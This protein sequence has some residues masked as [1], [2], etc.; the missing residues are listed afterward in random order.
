MDP[1][2][3]C[4]GLDLY[5]TRPSNACKPCRSECGLGGYISN[6]CMRNSTPSWDAS[7][8]VSCPACMK[9]EYMPTPCSGASYKDDKI[10]RNCTFGS[11]S[12]Q[13]QLGSY[14]VDECLSG[15]NLVD[16]TRCTACPSNCEAA[17]Y[18]LGKDGQYIA[19]FCNGS[20][21][22]SC[23]NCD[24]RCSAFDASRPDDRPGQ[25]I[26]SFCTG[27]TTKNRECLDCRKSCPSV[28]EFINGT[29]NGMDILDTS[30]CSKCT[31][32]K[33]KDHYTLNA[34]NI[35]A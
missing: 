9:G 24:G 25:Y 11:S 3:V 17:N 20:V 14:I 26:S 21:A 29:C 4:S 18:S 19:R 27:T 23:G 12:E 30:V 2:I 35:H 8:C 10:C 6:R 31:A 32:R 13:C 16:M 1:G 15:R 7:Y 5:D 22:T 28:D 34:C 33:S